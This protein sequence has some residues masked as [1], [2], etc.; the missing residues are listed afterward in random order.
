MLIPGS[1]WL[2]K[3]SGLVFYIGKDNKK[4]WDIG[5][6]SEENFGLVNAENADVAYFPYLTGGKNLEVLDTEISGEPQR[7]TPGASGNK[8]NSIWYL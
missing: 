8:K 4:L 3:L 7:Q 1:P 2:V 5:G 6:L